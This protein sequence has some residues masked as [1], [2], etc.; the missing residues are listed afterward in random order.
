M[1][2]ILV[3][4]DEKIVRDSLTT[5]L[6]D[7]GHSVAVVDSGEEA[8]AAIKR[9]P[10]Q[11]VISDFKLP[12]ID[13]VELM[14][15]VHES[16]PDLPFV[17]ITAYASVPSAVEAMRDGAYDYIEKP[18]CPERIELLI[19]KVL[20]HQR[21]V[22]ENIALKKEL[23]E[24]KK[25]QE[26]RFQFHDLIG[27]SAK[28]QQLFE[29]AR[30]VARSNAT[31]LVQ[32]D[33]GTGKELLARAIHNAS[34]RAGKPFISISCAALPESLLESELFGHER[35]SFTGAVAQRKGNFELADTGTLFL[36]EIG[37]ISPNVQVHLLR[38]LEEREFVRVGGTQRIKVDVRIISATNK[39]LWA[40]VQEG[41][42]RE[43]LYYRLHVVSMVIP[44]LRDRREDIVPLAQHFLQ[45]FTRENDKECP[46]LSHEVIEILMHYDWPGNVREL[47]NVIEHAV[48]L[49]DGPAVAKKDLPHHIASATAAVQPAAAE[50]QVPAKQT[51]IPFHWNLGPVP[52]ASE[53]RT[54]AGELSTS[55]S[56]AGVVSPAVSE[57][58]VSASGA[59]P[60]GVSPGA[61]QGGRAPVLPLVELE[62]QQ[63]LQA[64]KQTGGNKKEAARLLGIHRMTLH[65]KLK[66]MNQGL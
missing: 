34:P 41:K 21:V 55:G 48:V 22:Q 26:K 61:E 7:A 14:R 25:E 60:G 35:G 27:K 13:G 23:E 18:F 28:M 38:V 64:M 50:P 54:H 4:D 52:A 32:G 12:G 53:P 44:P 56:S 16:S 65:K 63:I 39:N 3:V 1:P 11:I 58:R 2:T 24:R 30:T 66:Q 57:P 36:D 15:R 29:F 62:R 8:L 51:G 20:A 10:P 49:C 37:D 43:D 9:D 59:S 47:E 17:I 42:F 46:A 33:S 19:K 5:W 6:S 45:K 40:R 31:V